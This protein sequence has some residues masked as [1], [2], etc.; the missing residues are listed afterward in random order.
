M[1]TYRFELIIMIFIT[2]FFVGCNKE[3]NETEER[4]PYED[5]LTI[6]K[7]NFPCEYENINF[8]Y[9]QELKSTKSSG[10]IANFITFPVIEDGKVIGRYIGFTD[11]SCAVYI[12]MKDYTNTVTVYDAINPS[13]HET[14]SMV[15]DSEKGI[16]IPV[17]LKSANGFLCSTLCA[18]GTI[19][20]A[21]SD[22]PVPVMDA[23]AATYAI[24][25]L[26]QCLEADMN[27]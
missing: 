5:K 24:A 6:F 26:A 20:I 13:L 1:K 19:A 11:Q 22:G 10:S 9:L 7:K 16:Y 12:D 2:S 27:S 8:D 25:C 23:L 18:I 4:N 15:Y 21:A 17:R 3:I 14:V